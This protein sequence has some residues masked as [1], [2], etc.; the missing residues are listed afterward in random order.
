MGLII[1]PCRPLSF[2]YRTVGRTGSYRELTPRGSLGTTPYPVT[3]GYYEVL[4]GLGPYLWLCVLYSLSIDCACLLTSVSLMKG[5]W[6]GDKLET[7]KVSNRTS[8]YLKGVHYVHPYGA[9]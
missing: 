2:S 1:D 3:L 5:V 4:I 8:S 9:T 7:L 6:W